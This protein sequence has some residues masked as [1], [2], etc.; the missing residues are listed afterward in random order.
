MSDIS[1]IGEKV[2]KIASCFF[3]FLGIE[4]KIE[5]CYLLS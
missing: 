2:K 1:E 5:K 3:L 4:K